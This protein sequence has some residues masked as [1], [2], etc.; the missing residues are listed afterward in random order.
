MEG[1]VAQWAN[2]SLLYHGPWWWSCDQ[3]TYLQLQ[4]SKFESCW[5]LQNKNEKNKNK[6]KRA[7]VWPIFLKKRLNER[8]REFPFT[9][10]DV[11]KQ[12]LLLIYLLFCPVS[13]TPLSLSISVTRYGGFLHLVIFWAI[14]KNISLKFKTAMVTTFWATFYFNI[15]PHCSPPYLLSCFYICKSQKMIC[16][17]IFHLVSNFKV[18]MPC[19]VFIFLKLC[20]YVRYYTHLYLQY[21]L[22]PFD[23]IYQ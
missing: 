7:W 6:Q 2:W 13:I 4:W 10:T 8:P 1:N 14:L 9:S 23:T 18:G 3:H 20:A 12:F 16:W 11:R 15:W 17:K 22:E 21:L 19:E 5:R